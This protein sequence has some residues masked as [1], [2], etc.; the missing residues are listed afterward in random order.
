[1]EYLT[2][3]GGCNQEKGYA[4]EHRQKNTLGGRATDH[5]SPEGDCANAEPERGD[6]GEA[7]S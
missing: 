2:G 6:D 5:S 7:Y 3:E 4:T 1:V